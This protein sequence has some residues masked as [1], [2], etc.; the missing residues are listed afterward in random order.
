MMEARRTTASRIVTVLGG[1]V[2]AA[3]LL[4]TA[5]PT[6]GQGL[7]I[8]VQGGPTFADLSVSNGGDV[9]LSSRTGFQVAGVLR[10]G[11]GGPLGIQTG[12]GLAQKG[13]TAP[14]SETGLQQ[15]VDYNLSYVE[16]P[17]LLTVTVPTPGAVSPRVYGGG[18]VSIESTCEIATEAQG[19]SGTVDCTADALGENA[20]N[21]ESTTYGLVFG[22]G[23]DFD[24]GGPL[25]ITLDGRYDLGLTDIN[26][27]TDPDPAEIKNRSFSAS[28]GILLSLP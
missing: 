11:F 4:V 27:V 20:L 3:A 6:Q 8:G 21:T 10:Y 16:V 17:L 7:G 5:A 13:A 1:V 2:A 25:A 26:D 9:D 14:P 12:V 22:G 23:V 19:V 24:L 18:Q 15:D 28:A